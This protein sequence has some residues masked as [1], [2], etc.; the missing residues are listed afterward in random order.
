MDIHS[1]KIITTN[2]KTTNNK[3]CLKSIE[4]SQ[5]KIEFIVRSIYF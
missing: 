5:I 3:L 1:G 2:A 4:G